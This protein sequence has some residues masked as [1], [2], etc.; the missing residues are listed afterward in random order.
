MSIEDLATELAETRVSL[1]YW[2]GV[3]CAMCGHGP[4]HM[5]TKAD[6]CTP[7]ERKVLNAM[8][9]LSDD[10]LIQLGQQGNNEHDIAET[11]FARRGE[12]P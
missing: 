12:E 9:R 8:A 7:A 10:E 5:T 4:D 2:K 11:E 6:L 1:A 3:H